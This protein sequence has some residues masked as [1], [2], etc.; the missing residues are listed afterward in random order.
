MGGGGPVELSVTA[1]AITLTITIPISLPC[2]A[3]FGVGC[4]VGAAL[5]S[6]TVGQSGEERP[7][8][9]A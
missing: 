6:L 1:T 5:V 4:V 3:A 8:K 7:G 2:L 9:Y